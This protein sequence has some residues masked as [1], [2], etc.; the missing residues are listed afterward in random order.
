MK[1]VVATSKDGNAYIFDIKTKHLIDRVCFKCRPDSKNML[2]RACTFGKDGSLYTLSTVAREPTFVI[3]WKPQGEFKYQADR[4]SQVYNKS[5]T[6]MRLSPN[7]ST[8]C[9]NTSDGFVNIIDA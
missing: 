2:M 1:R 7:G 4:T 6:G 9:V 8:I 3:K 5:S